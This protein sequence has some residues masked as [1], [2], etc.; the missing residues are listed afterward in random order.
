MEPESSLSAFQDPAC[1]PRPETNDSTPYP[2]ILFRLD[3]STLPVHAVTLLQVFLPKSC[4]YLSLL[5]QVCNI[6]DPA[7]ILAATLILVSP[8]WVRIPESL[9][10]KVVNFVILYIVCV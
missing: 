4:R 3:L 2:A 7:L 1:R 9:P 5:S 8:F 10:T 6:P